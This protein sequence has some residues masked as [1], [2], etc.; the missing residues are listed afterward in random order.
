[1]NNLGGELIIITFAIISMCAFDMADE[2]D[3]S[4]MTH[5]LLFTWSIFIVKSNHV[6][7]VGE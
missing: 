7:I 4:E 5:G 1:V 2:K 3:R 6:G